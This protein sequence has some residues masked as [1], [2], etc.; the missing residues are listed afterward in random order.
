MGNVKINSAEGQQFD[1]VDMKELASDLRLAE[2]EEMNGHQYAIS[3][4]Q[5]TGVRPTKIAKADASAFGL[6]HAFWDVYAPVSGSQKG[7]WILEKDADTGD[8]F[9]TVKES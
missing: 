1:A 7:Q 9:I 5:A 2:L 4:Y 6:R 8:E 3:K